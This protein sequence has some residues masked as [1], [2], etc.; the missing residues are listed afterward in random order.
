MPTKP[1]SNPPQPDDAAQ[2]GRLVQAALAE[3]MD[4]SPAFR[5]LAVNL[6]AWVLR[7]ADASSGPD[8]A[9]NQA[10]SQ[11]QPRA[12]PEAATE[13]ATEAGPEAGARPGGQA[14]T[15]VTPTPASITGPVSRVPLV[16]G[17]SSVEV[18]V[19][20][21]GASIQAARNSV[22]VRQEAP[23]SE[24]PAPLDL[25][26]ISARSKLKADACRLAIRRR[27]AAGDPTAEHAVL[28][29]MNQQ[30]A[31]AKSMTDCF[32][33]SFWPHETQPSDERLDAI[34]DCYEALS[35]AAGLCERLT[36]G[37]AARGADEMT[38]AFTLMAQASSALRIALG[39]SWLRSDDVDQEE[40]HLWLRHETEVRGIF[41]PRHMRLDDPADP[42][43][44]GAVT[45]RVGAINAR[46]DNQAARTRQ[47]DAALNR[48]RYHAKRFPG[49]DRPDARADTHDARRVNEALDELTQTLGLAATHPR[50]REALN[51]ITAAA[52]PDDA[53]AAAPVLAALGAT[54][55]GAAGAVVEQTRAWSDRVTGLRAMLSGG[56]VVII[57]GEPRADAI[58]RIEEAFGLSEVVWVELSEHGTGQPMRAPIFRPETLLVVVIIKLAGHLHAEEARA[59]AREADKPCVLLTAG[60]N[61]EQI[62]SAIE[63]QALERLRSRVEAGG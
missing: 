14:G 2:L 3:Q 41:V 23:A 52:F 45:E 46:L 26:L 58:E 43:G 15:R 31:K 7:R 27:A 54:T 8:G 53:P 39:W 61:P 13:A 6:A 32:L 33:W 9:S 38:E 34:A 10:E 25:S 44:A 21:D 28:E 16:I 37:A 51:G 4:R 50:I 5:E 49:P 12:A 56:S 60:Y 59:Y 1:T 57:G 48:V 17:G 18:A 36:A 29:V 20:G 40:S 22:P 63:D 55:A 24:G 35:A 19:R 42:A 30:I 62:A 47:V 11:P